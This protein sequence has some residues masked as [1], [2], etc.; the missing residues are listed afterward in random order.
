MCIAN[1]STTTI[2][3][4][5]G[6]LTDSWAAHKHSLMTQIM[7][8]YKICTT[9]LTDRMSSICDIPL[10]LQFEQT[11]NTMAELLFEI[12][13]G[14]YSIANPLNQVCHKQGTFTMFCLIPTSGCYPEELVKLAHRNP[15]SPLS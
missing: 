14:Q 13:A 6:N 4:H 9:I 12:Q 15:L 7:E 10:P 8:I 1:Q 11:T 3:V 5:K 2:F